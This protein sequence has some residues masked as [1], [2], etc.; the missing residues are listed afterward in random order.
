MDFKRWYHEGIVPRRPPSLAVQQNQRAIEL[1]L[2]KL[3]GSGKTTD[4]LEVFLRSMAHRASN[5][6]PNSSL[7]GRC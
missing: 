3:Q 2:K 6:L 7:T 4:D 1:A 5:L